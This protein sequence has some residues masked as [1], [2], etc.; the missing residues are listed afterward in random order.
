[1]TSGAGSPATAHGRTMRAPVL[2][3]PGH[4]RLEE[5]ERPVPGPDQL[6]VRIQGSGVCG[7]DLGPWTGAGVTDYPLR[8]GAPGH[9]G[10]GIV[11]ALGP[12][13]DGPAPGTRVATLAD[14][15][16]G[17]F[18]L[19]RPDQVVPLPHAL[20][21]QPFPAEALGCAMNVFRRSGIEPGQ[22]VAVVG[23]GFLGAL[24]VRLAADAGARVL[25]ISRRAFAR[26]VGRRMGADA[27]CPLDDPAA[28]EERAREWNGGALCDRVL[29]VT[30]KQAGLDAASPLVRVRGRL[31][32][33]GYH[34]GGTRTVD[35]QSWNW[36]GLDVI[37][38]HERDPE[39]YLRG[40]REAVAAVEAGRLD[41]GPLITHTFP[42]DRLGDALEMTRARPDGFL[43]AVVMQDAG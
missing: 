4:V 29:E 9:E 8:P 11:D 34:Q 15:A 2:E 27:V 10:W 36:R 6:R 35:M 16:Y 41:I 12:G 40:I 28:V 33:A 30:G 7:S 21:G 1:M 38:A 37:N 25:A 39:E 23:V 5:V 42:A 24:L 31:V 3:R 22:A 14:A 13:V 19:D 43:K 26:E 18:A 32:I 20:D 17:A